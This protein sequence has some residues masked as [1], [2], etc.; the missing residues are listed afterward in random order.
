MPY[1]SVYITF[2]CGADPYY[3]IERNNTCAKMAAN[4]RSEIDLGA[5][6]TDSIIIKRSEMKPF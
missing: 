4:F 3:N 6:D 2:C 5:C 1:L